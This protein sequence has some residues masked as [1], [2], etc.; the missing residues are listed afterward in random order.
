MA[1]SIETRLPFLDYRLVEFA[2]SLPDHRKL[3]GDTTKAILREALAERIP[4]RV[5]DRKDKMGFE[6]PTDAWLRERWPGEVRRRLAAG[7]PLAEWLDGSAV[8][9]Q[10][11]RYFEGRRPIGLQVWR[12][13]SL[14]SWARRYVAADPR[15]IAPVP[16]AVLHAGRHRGWVEVVSGLEREAEA[17]ALAG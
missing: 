12:W 15:Q 14:E 4:K 6:T 2:F 16:E 13:L 1:F 11:D 9:E 3:A 7:G 8:T 5:L 10:L 17:S